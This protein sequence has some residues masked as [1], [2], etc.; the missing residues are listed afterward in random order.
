VAYR[1]Q[2]NER[3]HSALATLLEYKYHNNKDVK[4]STPIVLS[5]ENKITMGDASFEINKESLHAHK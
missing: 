4:S 1:K 3:S 5:I 2:T